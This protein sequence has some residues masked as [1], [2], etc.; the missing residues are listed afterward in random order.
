MYNNEQ[1]FKTDKEGKELAY[2]FFKHFGYTVTAT[3][4]EY[5]HLDGSFQALDGTIIG[6]E[7]KNLSMDRYLEYDDILIAQDKYEYAMGPAI[8]ISGLSLTVKFDYVN[9]SDGII[10][11]VTRFQDV[12]GEPIYIP[13]PIGNYPNAPKRKMPMYSV[14]RSKSKVYKITE[15]KIVRIA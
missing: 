14:P 10:V 1:R 6:L 13:M 7:V 12:E 5:D 2:N 3:T 4:N 8:D 15:E 9:T 11:F